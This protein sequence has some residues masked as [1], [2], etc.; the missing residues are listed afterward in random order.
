MAKIE[1]RG[2]R[3]LRKALKAIERDIS[4]RGGRMVSAMTKA[5]LLAHRFASIAVHVDTGRLKNSLHPEV[6]ERGNDLVGSVSTNL[7]YAPYEFSLPGSGQWGTPHNTLIY[8]HEQT[9]GQVQALLEND[10][11][12]SI[13]TNIG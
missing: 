4:G 11:H 5:T 13:R 7:S 6:N 1:I 2:V 10:L 9:R 12:L 8:T 3:K